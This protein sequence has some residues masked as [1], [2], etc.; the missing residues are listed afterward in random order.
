VPAIYIHNLHITVIVAFKE[1][2]ITSTTS[3]THEL[4]T[5]P[6]TTP[7]YQLVS[8][9]TDSDLVLVGIVLGLLILVVVRTFVK[10]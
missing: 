8:I 9:R 10:R 4:H 5:K 1:H 3:H 2:T 7:T 6:N